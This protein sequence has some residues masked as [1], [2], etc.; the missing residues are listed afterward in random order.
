M[1]NDEQ[2]KEYVYDHLQEFDLS[3]QNDL[4]EVK[5]AFQLTGDDGKPYAYTVFLEKNK[6]DQGDWLVRTIVRADEVQAR[7]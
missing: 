7:E 4:G 5:V 1:N 3:D 6:S 2:I